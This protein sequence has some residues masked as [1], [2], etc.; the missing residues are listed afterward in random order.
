MHEYDALQATVLNNSCLDH[1]NHSDPK[2]LSDAPPVNPTGNPRVYLRKTS[3]L[4]TIDE[5]TTSCTNSDDVDFSDYYCCDDHIVSCQSSRSYS[6]RV[7][8][9]FPRVDN[10]YDEDFVSAYKP[11]EMRCLALVAHNHMKPALVDFVY[12]NRNLLKKFRLTGT[13]TTMTLL[14]TVYGKKSSVVY[15]PTCTSGPLGGDAEL[16]ALMCTGQ[17]GGVIFF[18]DPMSAHPHAADIACLNRQVVVHNV[19]FMNNPVSANAGA[20]VLRQALAEGKSELI[21]SFFKTLESPSVQEYKDKQEALLKQ[22]S[23]H[24]LDASMHNDN[25]MQIYKRQYSSP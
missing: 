6:G 15:G 8:V 10:P 18:I 3:S 19:F 2:L 25:L 4:N 14:N 21:P 1:T 16:V 12:A 5:K 9:L 7:P 20:H 13:K 11:D 23:S 24:S 17:L 22:G